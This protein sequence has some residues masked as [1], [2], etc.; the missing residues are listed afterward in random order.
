MAIGT[1]RGWLYELLPAYHREEDAERGAPL[2]ALLALIEAQADA[3]DADIGNLWDNFFIET[4]DRWTI[5][6]LGDLVGNVLLHSAERPED[7][8]TA[9]SLFPDLVGP[10]L[11]APA[12][13]RTRADVAKTI[14][15]RRRKATL[16]MLEEL[17]RD[18]TGWAAHAVEFFE[19]LHWTQHLEHVRLHSPGAAEV[20]RPE[21]VGRAHGPFS[22]ASYTVDVRRI[23]QHEGWYNIKNLGFFLWRL[24]SYPLRQVDARPGPEPWSFRFSPLGNDAPLF[25]RWR[26]EGDEAGLATEL[27]VP[28]PIR[29]A[30]FH[31]DLRRTHAAVPV[32][33]Q[34]EYY[35]HP[36]VHPEFSLA[37]TIGE[38]PVPPEQ[39]RCQRLEPWMQPSDPGAVAI[40]VR[41]GRIA[42]GTDWDT[43]DPVLVDYHY[44]FCADLG[45]G[46][47]ERGRWLVQDSLA[48]L[49]LTVGQTAPADATTLADALD[50]WAAA[51]KPNTIIRI[52]DS[53]SYAEALSIE[54][55]A[56]RWLVIEADGGQRPHL[57][58]GG[59]VITV[60]A[61]DATAELTLSGL[62]VE[63]G[64]EVTGELRRLRIL[65]TTLVPGRG[66]AEDGMP[67]SDEPAL[68][69]S[70]GIPAE[71]QNASLEVEIAFSI[72][73]PLRLPTHAS[74]LWLLDSIVD[75]IPQ[76]DGTWTTAVCAPDIPDGDGPPAHLERST[77]FGAMFLRELPLGSES[78]F[79]AP[80]QVTR[81]HEGCLR[82]SFVPLTSQ[83][84]Q[85]YRCQPRLAMERDP[86]HEELIAAALLP[87]FTAL[88]Y[89]HPG[90]A[91]LRT[92]APV[93]IRR[94]AADEAEM[95]AFNHLK[96]PQREANLR[97]RL[98]EYL[99]VGLEAGLIYVT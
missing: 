82:F 81:R 45:G 61:G 89:G 51:L 7:S 67:A 20:R 15:Y 12:A 32:P 66:L 77:V 78:I 98:E 92:G 75:G 71:P 24:R 58:P 93:E 37:V 84:P 69:V 40:D 59:G 56:G 2:A 76:P 8:A 85:Q 25:A 46:P 31:E 90:Y 55:E 60:A 79:T 83:T 99:P 94:G 65:H 41:R 16:P 19:R 27:H 13:V 97:I 38:T 33:P 10:H 18:V 48:D 44:G 9:Q 86:E 36:M 52:L 6:Y 42:L 49:V 28:G 70:P 47:Y 68:V 43:D 95:G 29:P 88:H 96:Q 64:I 5:P 73:G 91:Q 1:R 72:T 74:K 3:L 23:V 11:R 35:G 14:Y 17:A 34:S 87:G 30:A 53:R 62:L 39:I 21:V 57:Q 26:R 50:L 22:A 63:G 80:V 54:P 4:A